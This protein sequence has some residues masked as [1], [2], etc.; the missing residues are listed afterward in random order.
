MPIETRIF[1]EQVSAEPFGQAGHMYLARR[2]GGAQRYPSKPG[3]FT[4]EDG[5]FG[6]RP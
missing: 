2:M 5:E 4:D 1:I 6:E 3:R